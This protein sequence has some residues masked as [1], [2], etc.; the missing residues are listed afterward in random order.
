MVTVVVGSA[1]ALAV[2]AAVSGLLVAGCGS[3]ADLEG[4]P[5]IA[6]GGMLA[7]PIA[8]RPGDECW[9]RIGYADID[10]D[11]VAFDC[12]EV[13]VVGHG[14]VD[15]GIT[16]EAMA[17]GIDV[18]ATMAGEVL[19]VRDDRY[20]RCDIDE[21]HPECVEPLAEYTRPGEVDGYRVCTERSPEFCAPGSTISSCY[22]CTRSGNV[23]WLRHV[24]GEGR[25]FVTHYSHL[26]KGSSL[27]EV[28]NHVVGG[29]ALAQVGASGYA[30][31]PHLHFEVDEATWK[32][33]TD[34]FSGS[35]S[36][37]GQQDYL[38]ANEPAWCT[39]PE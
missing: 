5:C 8:C 24:D 23:V 9:R 25:A 31:A 36:P 35:C 20:D 2:G 11:G 12:S 17:E 27:V 22:R 15:L 10:E 6:A 26:R 18:L 19:F 4:E 29:Q 7:W 39:E 1:R 21:E 16:V 28:G 34:P 14:G 37:E 13:G 30:T 33:P 38:F 3:S 32:S